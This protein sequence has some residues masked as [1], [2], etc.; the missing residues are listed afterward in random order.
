M[1][2]GG[3]GNCEGGECVGWGGGTL[4]AGLSTYLSLPGGN[5]WLTLLHKIT[6]AHPPSSLSTLKFTSRDC[7]MR[8]MIKTLY[9]LGISSIFICNYRMT[10]RIGDYVSR[11]R[12]GAYFHNARYRQLIRTNH[13]PAFIFFTKQG[14][15]IPSFSLA[16]HFL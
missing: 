3:G 15:L 16:Q 13:T 11:T 10:S 9:F 14:K 4:R 6:N 5:G 12:I 8:L 2:L 1:V 7:T